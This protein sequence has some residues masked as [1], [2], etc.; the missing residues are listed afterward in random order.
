MS[1]GAAH[2]ISLAVSLLNKL[3]ELGNYALPASLTGIIDT[4]AVVHFFSSVKTE[5]DVVALAVSEV[6][7]VV[8]DQHSV[9]GESETEILARIL[10]DASGI[11]HQLLDNVKIHQ[12]LTAEEIDLKVMS[13]A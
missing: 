3:L 6:N 13:F 12:R 8:I 10:L 5:H 2:I 1:K 7:N 9:G 4:I 11:C